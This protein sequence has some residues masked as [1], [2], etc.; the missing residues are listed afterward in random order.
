V[1]SKNTDLSASEL[2]NVEKIGITAG[3]SAVL[4]VALSTA[5]GEYS[6]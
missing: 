5:F 3:C 6:E 2:E 1:Y 4:R